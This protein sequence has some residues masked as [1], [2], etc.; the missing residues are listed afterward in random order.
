MPRY[1]KVLVGILLGLLL[2]VALCVLLLATFDWNHAR[3]WVARQA[4]ALTHRPVSIEG[5]LSV[6]WERAPQERGWQ[7]W[8][9]WPRITAEDIR[10]GNPDWTN[11]PAQ[12]GRAGRLSVVIAPLP[13]LSHT[14]RIAS[15]E[16]HDADIG[17][18]R[19]EDGANNWSTTERPPEPAQPPKWKV[20]LRRLDLRD[21]TL[22]FQDAA[23]Q[24]QVQATLD[25]LGQATQQG[26][27]IGWKAR[28]SYKDAKIQGQGRAGGLLSLQENGKPFPIQAAVSVGD[29]KIE[30]EG[31]V[32]QPSRLAALDLRLAL[33]GASMAD[34]NPLIGIALPNT[35]AY[36]TQ[37]RLVGDL[38][39]DEN[40]WRYEDFRGKVG[41]SDLQGTLRY[42]VRKPRSLLSGQVR[43][44]LLRFK[45]LGPLVGVD[46]RKDKDASRQ[47]ADKA[48]PVNP[49]NTRSWRIMDAD[50][51]FQG[52]KIVRSENLP[53]DNV[54]AHVKLQDSV[55]TLI[56]LN[57]GVAGGTLASNIRLDGRQPRIQARLQASARH[58]KLRKLIPAAESMNASLGEMHGDASLTGQGRSFAELLGGANGEI[59]AVVS[60]G[61]ISHFLLE[62]AGLNIADMVIVKLFGDDQVVLNCLAS[63]FDVKNGLMR[64]RAFK[65]DTEDA[66]VDITGDINLDTEKLDLDIK[67]E[68]KSLRVFTLRTPLYV[69]GTFKNPDVGVHKGPIA[70]RAG[71]AVVLGVVAT[72]LAALVPLLNLGT[73]D[74]NEC[75]PLLKAATQKPKAPPPGKSGAQR[76]AA[77]RR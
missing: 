28:G 2:I 67:P 40:T 71:A 58:L 38:A 72:P 46:K 63:D 65:L 32:T 69:R 39:T 9:P 36:S 12:M 76:G 74:T 64:T 15:L 7:A 47:P 23:R 14:A 29:T 43:S 19:R 8:I 50:V 70:A 49:I 59:K 10:I 18:R 56:P 45:D 4:S 6:R 51:Q 5:S 27:A 11:P 21:V 57:F 16:L 48:L 62:A 22:R 3:P 42:Q 61:T 60:K 33:Q 34:L 13:L 31:T 30:V 20:D 1:A 53:L 52:L 55:L 77:G 41:S 68:N 35:P 66:T 25:S 54:K 37:G 26:Y 17:L 75:A 24:V 73:A 44:R